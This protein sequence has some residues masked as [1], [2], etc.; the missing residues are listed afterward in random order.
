M[1]VGVNDSWR[2]TYT[3]N[4]FFVQATQEEGSVSILNKPPAY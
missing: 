4:L 3:V 1:G 2:S